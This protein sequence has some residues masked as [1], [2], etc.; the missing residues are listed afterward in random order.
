MRADA[1]G[2]WVRRLGRATQASVGRLGF[3]SRFF[4]LVIYHSPAALK[5]LRLTMREIYFEGVLSLVIIMVSGLF[6]GMVLGLQGYD[7]LNKYG[8]DDSLGIF[9]G[10]SLVASACLVPAMRARR[11]AI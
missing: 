2:F 10:L 8:A 5:R 1:I 7:A 9:V 4:A 6:V 11:P 3:A